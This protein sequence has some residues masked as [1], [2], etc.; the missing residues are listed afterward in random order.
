MLMHGCIALTGLLNNILAGV[1]SPDLMTIDLT[2]ETLNLES[3]LL[4][5][6]F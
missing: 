3:V 1:S 5:M 4:S 2:E 6:H